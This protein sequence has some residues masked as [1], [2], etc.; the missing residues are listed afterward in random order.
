[1]ALRKRQRIGG[2]PPHAWGIRVAMTDRLLGVRFTPTRVGNTLQRHRLP[3]PLPGS[4]PHAWGI[5]TVTWDSGTNKIGSPPHAWG[6]RHWIDSNRNSKAVH[7]HTRGE[8]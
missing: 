8:Y 1:M 7:P 3:R 6:I 4:P 2:S 5:L